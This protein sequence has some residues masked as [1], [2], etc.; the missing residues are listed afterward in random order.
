MSALRPVLPVG[1]MLHVRSLE[2]YDMCRWF[3]H[4]GSEFDMIG[5]TT[6]TKHQGIIWSW[7]ALGW[8]LKGVGTPHLLRVPR[9]R[10]SAFFPCGGLT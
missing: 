4:Q 8:D 9:S 7:A 5:A 1:L 6:A 2:S 10:S 3:R